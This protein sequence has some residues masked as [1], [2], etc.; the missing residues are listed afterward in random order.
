MPASRV[1]LA[2]IAILPLTV[3]PPVAVVLVVMVGVP[4]EE[5]NVRLLK[6]QAVVPATEV[7]KFLLAATFWVKVL[8]VVILITPQVAPQATLP[9]TVT[10]AVPLDVSK[11]PLVM[12]RSLVT[13]TVFVNGLHAPP[14]PLKVRL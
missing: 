5:E 12:V 2:L 14:E 9:L 7:P 11:V 8:V 6:V 4:V 1:V 13:V 3:I 10:L